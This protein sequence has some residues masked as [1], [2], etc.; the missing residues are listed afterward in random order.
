MWVHLK[1]IPVSDAAALEVAK[2][3]L[4]KKVKEGLV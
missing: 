3:L 2:E 4:W 1:I